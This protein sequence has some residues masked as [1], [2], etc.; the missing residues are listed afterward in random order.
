MKDDFIKKA[1]ELSRQSFEEGKF[2]AGALLVQ[3]DEII[4]TAISSA[5]PD[6]HLHGET[7]VIDEGMAKLRKQLEDCELYTS[8][9][10]CLMCTG[11]IYWSGVSKVYYV[12]GREDTDQKVAYEGM[13]DSDKIVSQLNRKIEFIQDK[14]YFDEA[15]SIYKKWVEKQK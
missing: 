10:P 13:H 3:G 9:Q 11:K 14:T 8:M 5:F 7:K 6:F 1:V 4:T 15:L 12:L 2:P